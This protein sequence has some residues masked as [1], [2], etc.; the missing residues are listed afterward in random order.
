VRK[1]TSTHWLLLAA[2]PELGGAVGYTL[3][4]G[5]SLFVEAGEHSVTFASRQGGAL[6]FPGRVPAGVLIDASGE[7]VD[8]SGVTV[9][10]G[11]RIVAQAPMEPEPDGQADVVVPA[12][13][14]G[15]M[16]AFALAQSENWLKAAEQGDFTPVRG[17]TRAAPE[18]LGAE[19]EPSL[20]FDQARPVVA[21]PS[22]RG[23]TGAVGT[24]MN[25]AQT[26]LESGVPGTVI[27]GQRYR[28]SRII[29]NPGTTG[30]G[31]GAL[32]VNRAA[33][34]LVRLSRD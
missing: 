12:E 7:P 3:S 22:P 29:G 19:F 13:L 30:T 23:V 15:D 16:R 4:K 11:Q 10:Q 33:E 9:R 21:A 8:K 18:M 32:T 5:A 27:A 6:Y 34:L 14:P 31:T 26:L 1:P 2:G 28:R 25:P 17:A 20:V 24:T